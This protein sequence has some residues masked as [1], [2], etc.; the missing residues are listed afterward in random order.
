MRRSHHSESLFKAMPALVL[1]RL[2]HT[3]G[4]HA[5]L[6]GVAPWAA[7]GSAASVANGDLPNEKAARPRERARGMRRPS[8]SAT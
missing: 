2:R 3:G 7:A 6:S 1:L 8:V 5:A 4:M